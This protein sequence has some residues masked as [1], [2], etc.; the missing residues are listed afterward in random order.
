MFTNL[1]NLICLL[2]NEKQKKRERE[3]VGKNK[4]HPKSFS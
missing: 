4:L 3:R 1:I 2:K